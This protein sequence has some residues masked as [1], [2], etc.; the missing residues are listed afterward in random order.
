MNLKK[1]IND[2]HSL[3]PEKKFISSEYP[4]L[5]TN[6]SKDLLSDYFDFNTSPPN[7][8]FIIMESLSRSYSG[9]NAYLGSMTP[10]LDSLSN[11]GIYFENFINF[12]CFNFY[13][14]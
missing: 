14:N 9:K 4:L 13:Y 1:S 5:H 10:F 12:T 11:H 2:F 7:I 8:V 6:T 3:Y